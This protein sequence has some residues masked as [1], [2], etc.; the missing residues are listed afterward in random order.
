VGATPNGTVTLS[1]SDDAGSKQ[2]LLRIGNKLDSGYYA[3][4]EGKEP[5]YVISEYLGER[6]VP[7]LEKFKKDPPP[8]PGKTVE[9]Y[10][11]SVKKVPAPVATKMPGHAH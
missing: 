9:V 10:P 5:I 4:R 7:T 11:E 3:M 1:T 6:L 8:P 2:V